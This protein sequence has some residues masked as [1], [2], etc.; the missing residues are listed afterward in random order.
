[1]YLGP[2]LVSFQDIPSRWERVLEHPII[3]P[4]LCFV[5]FWHRDWA[6]SI[7]HWI[8]DDIGMISWYSGTKKL[9]SRRDETLFFM[10]ITFWYIALL[11]IEI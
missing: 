1:M 6:Y 11:F 2:V 5:H 8:S 10:K 3:T 9:S 4:N 7:L